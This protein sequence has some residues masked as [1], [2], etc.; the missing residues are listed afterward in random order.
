MDQARQPEAGVERRLDLAGNGLDEKAMLRHREGML[1]VG[2]AVPAGHAGKPVRDVL[3]L[4]I[5][6]RG[7]EQVEPP[8]AQHALPGA[9]SGLLLGRAIGLWGAL[10]GVT[11]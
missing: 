2:L 11:K 10:H 9:R 6:R 1:A 3:D 5:E 8:P 7:V 4:D